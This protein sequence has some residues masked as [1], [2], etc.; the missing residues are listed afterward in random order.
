MPK[1][2]DLRV[3]Y[4]LGWIEKKKA[5]GFFIDE[6]YMRLVEKWSG[7]TTPVKL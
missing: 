3:Q 4:L 1:N 6:V 7:N 5:D 2:K